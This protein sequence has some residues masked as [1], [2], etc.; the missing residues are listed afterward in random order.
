[1]EKAFDCVSHE[2]LL[3]KLRYYGIKE[4]QHRLYKSYLQ[5]RYQRT[6][7]RKGQ[8]N[9]KVWS[10]WAKVKNGVPQGSVL[11]PLLFILFINDLPKILEANSLPIL[12]ADDTSVVISHTN[13]VKFKNQINEVYGILKDWFNKNLL[14][15]N[16][17][18]TCCTNFTAN[19]N[20]MR[21][22]GIGNLMAPPLTSN[23]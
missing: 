6:S 14:S 16:T 20:A 13:P 7:I 18:K 22:M 21:G 1:L 10:E 15:L 17:V 12:F 11:G 4:K 19:K 5:D 3:D 23:S 9:D 8:A 2:V